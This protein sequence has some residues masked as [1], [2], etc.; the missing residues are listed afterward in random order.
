MEAALNLGEAGILKSKRRRN[1]RPPSVESGPY[2]WRR[3]QLRR[4]F[5]RTDDHDKIVIESRYRHVKDR[6]VEEH[7]PTNLWADI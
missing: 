4:L 6:R 1:Q 3:R 7:V 2:P 5:G